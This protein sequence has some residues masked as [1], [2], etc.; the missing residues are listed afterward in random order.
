MS[1][2]RAVSVAALVA[3][4]TA[5]R[6]W[7]DH[8]GFRTEGMNPIW[9]AVLWAAVAFLLG[10]AI[11]GIVSVVARRRAPRPPDA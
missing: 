4:V 11:V 9:A 1:C 10:M 8:G 3:G 7:A 6:A 2:G 5:S